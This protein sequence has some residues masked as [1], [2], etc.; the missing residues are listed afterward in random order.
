[1]RGKKEDKRCREEIEKGVSKGKYVVEQQTMLFYLK[2]AL[3]LHE[4]VT[5]ILK[6]F[7]KLIK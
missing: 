4:G 6:F 5:Q 1:L 3:H 7:F 2:N